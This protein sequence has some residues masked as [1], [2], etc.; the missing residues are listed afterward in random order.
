MSDSGRHSAIDDSG[1]GIASEQAC[2]QTLGALL[3][4]YD[5]GAGLQFWAQHGL[6]SF[7]DP[8]SVAA[9]LIS[10]DGLS[11]QRITEYITEPTTSALLCRAFA[12]L[13]VGSPPC[14]I[15][16]A[17]RRYFSKLQ[18]PSDGARWRRLAVSFAESFSEANP[19]AVATAEQC[20]RV[21]TAILAVNEGLHSDDGASQRGRPRPMESRAGFTLE[22][23]GSMRPELLAAT[24]DSIAADALIPGQ[25]HTEDCRTALAMLTR[26]GPTDYEDPA[27]F[28]VAYHEVSR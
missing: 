19:S 24:Y 16:D 2:I 12:D 25:D 9:L 28:Y 5:Q 18:M 8:V 10:T 20:E 6:C 4:N 14:P 27:R 17:L 7:T 15:I 23:R 13:L 26:V 21:I 22:L 11:F 3:F 1:G